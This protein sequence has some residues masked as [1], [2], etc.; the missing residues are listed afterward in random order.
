MKN[1]TKL[2]LLSAALICVLPVIIASDDC[3]MVKD[4]D[5]THNPE[6]KTKLFKGQQMFTI[7]FLDKALKAFPDENLFFSPYSLY[8]ALLLAYFGARNETETA[9]VESLKLH[10]AQDKSEVLTAYK[11]D[12]VLRSQNSKLEKALEFESVD[13]FFFDESVEIKDCVLKAF[14]EE[15]EK[16]D[17]ANNTEAAR[18]HINKFVEQVTRDQIKNLLPEGAMDAS[19]QLALANAANFKGLWSSKFEMEH[20]KKEIFYVRPDKNVFVDMMKQVGTF[21]FAANEY[22]GYHILEIPYNK[23]NPSGSD[24]S[25]VVFL[26]PFSRANALE[27]VLG[28]LTPE[29]LAQALNEG[30]PQKV[31]LK[32]P[33]FS[34]EKTMKLVPIFSA[35]GLGPIVSDDADFSGFSET[36]QITFND[37]IHKAKVEVDESGSKAAAA[38]VMFSFRSSRPID[39]VVFHA[40]HP[41]LFMIYDHKTRAILFAGVYRGPE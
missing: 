27:D 38:T 4:E 22:L 11:Q 26:P 33:K 25:F 18:Q 17:I 12:K 7:D 9:L 23:T 36:A 5:I 19:T 15:I 16:L 30:H 24:I 41:F 3:P 39:P 32:L 35:M 13:K 34:M 8:R 28:K 14:S 31:D 20:T 37:I 10:W 1:F 2:W 40:N 6:S 29:S 21:N